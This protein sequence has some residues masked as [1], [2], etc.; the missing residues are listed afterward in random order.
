MHDKREWMLL[1]LPDLAEQG[2]FQKWSDW[3]SGNCMPQEGNLDSNTTE[4]PGRS[5]QI[6]YLNESHLLDPHVTSGCLPNAPCN[7]QA[8]HSSPWTPGSLTDFQFLLILNILCLLLSYFS[9]F[10]NLPATKHF[11]STQQGPMWEVTWWIR[12]VREA[13]TRAPPQ[14]PHNHRSVELGKAMR[15]SAD[16]STPH[17]PCRGDL[18]LPTQLWNKYPYFELI[19]G[20]SH[21]PGRCICHI[22]MTYSWHQSPSP[23]VGSF[24]SGSLSIFPKMVHFLLPEN[25]DIFLTHFYISLSISTQHWDQGRWRVLT[26][27]FQTSLSI[28]QA[29]WTVGWNYFLTWSNPKMLR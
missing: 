8:G 3:N 22:P 1:E 20:L 29:N 6:V 5:I 10:T 9:V 2:S 21:F 17:R 23:T 28:P 11:N 25:I 14:G 24:S 27:L 19:I 12:E 15:L 26:M 7:P 18:A 4:T 16:H 13:G